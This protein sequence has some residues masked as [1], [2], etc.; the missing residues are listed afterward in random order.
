M[1]TRP[2][3]STN[4]VKS[5]RT[6]QNGLYVCNFCEKH[7]SFHWPLE[8]TRWWGW[9]K[10]TGI[11]TSGT[12]NFVRDFLSLL[13]HIS[14]TQSSK[15]KEM[16]SHISH[17]QDQVMKPKGVPEKKWVLEIFRIFVILGLFG[18]ILIFWACGSFWVILGH[19]GPPWDF[20]TILGHLGHSG[21]FWAFWDILRLLGHFRH[22]G[23]FGPPCAFWAILDNSWHVYLSHT[24]S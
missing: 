6:H 23:P 17:I 20:W 21:Q 16:K 12:L 1:K 15:F 4:N 9:M 11:G 13:P 18:Q 5:L 10:L 7:I 24:M 22:S 3:K 19:F 14:I 2:Q 8:K